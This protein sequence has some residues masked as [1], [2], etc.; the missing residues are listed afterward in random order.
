MRVFARLVCTLALVLAA[1]CG[2]PEHSVPDPADLEGVVWTGAY[3]NKSRWRQ[4]GVLGGDAPGYRE[5][6]PGYKGS[7]PGGTGLQPGAIDRVA[8]RMHIGL[9]PAVVKVG[10]GVGG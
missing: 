4:P 5:L 6:Q 2:E 7:Q 10:V 9:Q 1:G 3:A 8:A